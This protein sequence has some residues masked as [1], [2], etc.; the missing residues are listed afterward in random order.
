MKKK[1]IKKVIALILG[2]SLTASALAGC[3]QKEEQKSS[4]EATESVANTESTAEEE[5][6]VK[7][8]ADGDAGEENAVKWS[9]KISVAPYMFG[10]VENDKITPLIE[11]KLKEYGYDVTLE[12]VYLENSQYMELLN[13]RLASGDAPDIFYAA[14]PD[15]YAE[16][17]KQGLIASWDEA[18][19]REH[20]PNVAAFVDAGEPDGTN[21]AFSSQFWEMSKYEGKMAAIPLY[22]RNTGSL[23]NVIYNK[24]WLENLNAEVPETL[25]EFVELMYRFKNEDPDGNGQ[26]DTYGFSTSMLNVIFGAYGA[27][28]GF[29]HMDGDDYGHWYEVDGEMVAADIMDGNEEALKLIKQLYD[30]GII[31]P[32]FVTGENQGGYWALSHSFMNGRIGVTHTAR[33]AHYLPEL[34]DDAGNVVS[35]EGACLTEFK[36]IQGDDADVVV[37]PWLKGPNGD[38]GGFLR[39]PASLAGAILYN[40]SLNDDPEKLAAIFEIMDLFSTDDDLATLATYGIEGEDYTYAEEGYII[41][42][43]ETLPDNVAMNACGIW[44]MRSLYGPETPFN[45]KMFTVNDTSPVSAYVTDLKARYAGL[46]NTIGYATAIWDVLPS[47]GE[48][49]G[50]V[51]TYRDETWLNIIQGKTDLDWDGFVE[52]W[53]NRGGQILT[54]EA[55]QWYQEHK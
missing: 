9:G 5:S 25:D 48:Y 10:P 2:M 52:E 43:S 31:D 17:C 47:K 46:A 37:G 38:I 21:A 53:K 16:Y 41:R 24:Q 26:D 49:S 28:P 12:N 7:E 15:A 35:S 32:E 1:N 3:G 40:G 18:F 23:I 13:L 50:E 4:S 11:E 55:N 19:F 36:A 29:L 44:V 42:N 8:S 34:Y 22:S 33:Y 51:K 30:D 27:Y 6:S 39:S 14:G 20:A 45:Y 54:E